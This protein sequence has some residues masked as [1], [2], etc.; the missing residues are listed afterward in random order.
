MIRAVVT[1][2]EGTTSSLSFVKEVLFPYAR[3]RMAGFVGRNCDDPLVAR[4]LNEVR[5]MAGCDLTREQ[6]VDQLIRWIDDD[7][8]IAPLK[9]LQGMIWEKG[10]SE[11]DFYGHIYPDAVQALRSWHDAGIDLYLY[12]SGSVDAQR[13]LF[14][15]TEHGDL[16]PLFKGYFDLSVGHKT[17]VASYH[18]IVQQTG[19]P[20]NQILFLSDMEKE[21]D[22]AGDAGMMTFWLTR[23]QK[24]DQVAGHC[25]IGD[26]SSI[27]LR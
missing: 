2:I 4:L 25:Q 26:F 16:T 9:A 1:D 12:S 7:C 8:K 24:P 14:A 17:E 13:L 18:R 15:H 22:A 10:Y 23:G 27:F 6:L 19:L 3:E 11:G 20:S 5:E 21:L